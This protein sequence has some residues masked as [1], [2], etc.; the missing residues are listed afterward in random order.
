MGKVGE[1]KGTAGTTPRFSPRSPVELVRR[2]VFLFA[3][4]VVMAFGVALSIK[5]DLGTSPI[6][7]VPYALSEIV[8]LSVGATTVLLHCLLVLVQ[9]AVLRRRFTPGR[10]VQVPVGVLFGALTDIAMAAVVV[11]E[12]GAYWQR[13]L[14]CLAGV[15]LVAVGVA[16]EVKAD[17]VML[18]GEGT[19][20]AFCK[21]FPIQFGNM[22][23][24]FDVALVA[25]AC[26]L[27]V[28]FLGRVVGVR[29]GTLAAAVLVG[30]VSKRVGRLLRF[31]FA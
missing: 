17:V 29:E 2:Y 7:S 9:L 16:F 14:C 23:V 10:L 4:L 6:S 5:S 1:G 27:G 31:S 24:A 13:W 28:V 26:T 18:A 30:L 20:D 25:V 19:V 15:A 8:P 12:P 11:V 21:A 3:G 22:K